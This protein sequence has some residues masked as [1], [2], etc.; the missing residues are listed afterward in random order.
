MHFERPRTWQLNRQVARNNGITDWAEKELKRLRAAGFSDRPFA[1]MRTWG[2]G[3][4]SGVPVEQHEF[5][6]WT[7]R[8]GKLEQL[9]VY[10]DRSDAL[11]AVG[12]A[13]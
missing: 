3:R 4:R 11:E 7:V 5:H 2:R 8:D 1:V 6:V 13:G 12:L 9:R 10:T